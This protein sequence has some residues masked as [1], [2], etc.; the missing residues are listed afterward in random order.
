MIHRS[1]NDIDLYIG[2]LS[3]DPVQGGL[4][5]STFACILANQFKDMKRGDRF[6]YEN[7]PSPTSFTQGIF[8]IDWQN[9][10]FYLRLI[11]R[12]TGRD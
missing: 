8:S 2:G 3:E 10:Y 7:G 1:V 11:K 5:G 12:T 4:I 9:L 6:Y